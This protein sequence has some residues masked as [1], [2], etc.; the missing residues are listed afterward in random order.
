MMNLRT[1]NNQNAQNIKQRH[2]KD[3]IY[4]YNEYY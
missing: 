2:G 1:K 4:S 3:Y